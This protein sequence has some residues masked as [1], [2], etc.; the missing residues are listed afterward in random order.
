MKN[1]PLQNEKPSRADTSLP[2][3]INSPADLKDKSPEQLSE[4]AEQIRSMIISTVSHTGGHLSSNLGVTE[5]TIAL[6]VVFDFPRD[7]LLWDVGH[8][9]YAH[10]ILTGR[11]ER[12]HTLRQAGGISGYPAP[13][14][15]DYDLFATGHAGTSI[16]M[17]SGLAWADSAMRSASQNTSQSAGETDRKVVAVVG[18]AAIANG[19]ALEALNNA[20]LLKRQFLVILNDNSMA[21]DVTQGSLAGLLD[22]I[23][24]TQTYADIKQTTEQVLSRLPLGSEI[25]ETLRHIKDGLRT[26]VHGEQLFES[27]GFR[28]FGPVDGHDMEALLDIL[29]RVADVAQPVL[30]HVHTQKGRGCDYAVEDPCRFHSPSA[31]TVNGGVVEFPVRDRP[32]WTD[33]FSRTLIARA[34]QDEKIVAITA[35]MPDGTGLAD[36][37]EA[38]PDRYIDVGINESHAVAMAAGLAKAGL[39]PVVAIYSTFLQRAFD[40]IFEQISL[41]G[42]PVVFCIDR[43]GLVGTDGPTHHGLLDIAY[44][45]PLPG[46]VLMAPADEDE[47]VSALEMALS[48]EA[49]SAIRYPRDIVPVSVL[50]E[51]ASPRKPFAMGKACCVREGADGTFLALGAMVEYAVLAAE[52]LALNHEIDTTV[53]S[54]RFVKPLD[55]E[56][57]GDLIATGK[58]LLTVEDHSVACGFGSA[59]MELASSKSLDTSNVRLIGVPDRFIAHAG[60]DQQLAEIGLDAESLAETMRRCVAGQ[61]TPQ[62]VKIIE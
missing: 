45:R 8:Q 29:R 34:K 42:L 36:F 31:H 11:G 61:T 37:R 17:A 6:H 51:D 43:A 25:T 16:S 48:L 15:S 7:F 62:H 1:Q 32:T 57:I 22:R 35:A 53:V 24:L 27:L 5:L 13:S 4:I 12:F 39:K 41:Q 30:L 2:A 38:A 40:Q 9:C 33:V 44:L 58:P 59:V 52:I 23:R 47:M 19:V 50:A 26:T 14:E 55:E 56:L 10:K 28:Y 18:D 46:M 20:G 49:P 54:A 60:R 21:I 3:Q